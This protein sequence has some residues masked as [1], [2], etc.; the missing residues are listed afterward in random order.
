MTRTQALTKLRE[1]RE[2][3]TDLLKPLGIS[4]ETWLAAAGKYSP[5]AWAKVVDKILE[6]G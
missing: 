2:L 1:T 3:S 5:E 6:R 4:F